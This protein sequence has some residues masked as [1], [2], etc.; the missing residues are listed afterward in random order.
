MNK[1]LSQRNREIYEKKDGLN[2]NRIHTYRELS[3]V[4][5]LSVNRLQV[6]V[7]RERIKNGGNSSRKSSS[8]S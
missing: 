6:I 8:K 5:N 4:Y 2:G 3:Q 7:N 1:D